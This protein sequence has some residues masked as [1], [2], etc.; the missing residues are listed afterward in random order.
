MLLPNVLLALAWL[1]LTGQFTWFN[2]F[3][4]MALGYLLLWLDREAPE[5]LAYFSKVRQIVRFGF[6]F[7]AN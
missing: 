2:F 6:F 7:C 4:G 3:I 5:R 1:A